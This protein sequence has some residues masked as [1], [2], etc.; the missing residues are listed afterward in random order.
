MRELT[1][2]LLATARVEEG[3]M[4]ETQFLHQT[5]GASEELYN[6]VSIEEVVESVRK[7]VHGYIIESKDSIKYH[8]VL[9]NLVIEHRGFYYALGVQVR[10]GVIYVNSFI[11]E[12]RVDFSMS[13]TTAFPRFYL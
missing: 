6:A 2:S 8:K 5:N 1:L 7:G 3:P 11:N 13:N 4:F 12:G 10:D 9:I